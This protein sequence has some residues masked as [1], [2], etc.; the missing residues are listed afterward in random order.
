MARLLIAAG[1]AGFLAA[2]L[3]TVIAG[4]PVPQIHD[5]ISYLLAADTYA[6]GRLTN[7]PH[8]LWPWFETFHVLQQPTYM[9]KY[10]PAQ[11]LFLALGLAAFVRAPGHAS[12]DQAASVNPEAVRSIDRASVTERAVS[13]PTPVDSQAL[14]PAASHAPSTEPLV[15]PP[16]ATA[17]DGPPRAAAPK[18]TRAPPRP[19]PAAARTNARKNGAD[20]KD[21]Y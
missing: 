17:H 5:E 15:S 6:H 7:P 2:L 16:A 20:L 3:T 4:V 1:L 10:P 21:P 13:T 12:V 8:P 18:T 14:A 9:S 19:P 11:G